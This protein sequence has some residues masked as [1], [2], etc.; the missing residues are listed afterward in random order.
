MTY[1]APPI[2]HIV[3]TMA[4]M[5]TFLL[6][7]WLYTRA[8]DLADRNPNGRGRVFLTP[9]RYSLGIA[10]IMVAISDNLPRGHTP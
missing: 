6:T 9:N 3:Y 5:A 2:V 10:A 8:K 1:P 4:L 7:G